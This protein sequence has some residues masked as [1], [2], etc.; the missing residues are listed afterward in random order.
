MACVPSFPLIPTPICAS[1]IIGT[2]FAPS[3]IDTV[4]HEPFFFARP[5]TSAFYAGDTLQHIT[6]EAIRP[7][8]KNASSDSKVSK[9]I[10]RVGPSM[11]IE[12]LLPPNFY[13]L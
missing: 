10:A 9:A 12:S 8:L 2:S 13:S 1:R 7:N 4:I 6:E 5:T 11:T 3:P